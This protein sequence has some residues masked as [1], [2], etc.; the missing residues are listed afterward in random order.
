MQSWKLWSLIQN[1]SLDRKGIVSIKQFLAF[2]LLTAQRLSRF[3]SNNLVHL[4]LEVVC[5][6]WLEAQAKRG[7]IGL[8]NVNRNT[9]WVLCHCRRFCVILWKSTTKNVKIRSRHNTIRT[10]NPT[11]NHYSKAENAGLS[12]AKN[13]QNN[14]HWA[15]TLGSQCVSRFLELRST[16]EWTTAKFINTLE[17]L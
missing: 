14:C 6:R 2:W 4:Q 11:V 7:I 3:K 5:C 9:R 16:S 10:G 13:V 1:G 17:S 12:V 8:A 15:R